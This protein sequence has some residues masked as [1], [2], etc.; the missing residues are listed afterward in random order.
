MR[1][2]ATTQAKPEEVLDLAREF[3]GGEWGL[4]ECE[5][6]DSSA[7]FEGGGGGVGISATPAADGT[8]V[9]LLAREWDHQAQEFLRRLKGRG[10]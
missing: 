4:Q 8:E 1:Y 6:A 5:S 2:G 3:F 7:S 10:H 9:E